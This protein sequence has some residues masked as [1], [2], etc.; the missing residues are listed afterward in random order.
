MLSLVMSYLLTNFIVDF[1][2]SSKILWK[3]DYYYTL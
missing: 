3:I 1:F 2:L